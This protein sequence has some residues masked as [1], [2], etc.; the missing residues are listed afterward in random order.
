MDKSK[1]YPYIRTVCKKCRKLNEKPHTAE[2][3]RIQYKN[4]K[5]VH[6]AANKRWRT[7]NRQKMREHFHQKRLQRGLNGLSLERLAAFSKLVIGGAVTPK[8]LT[9]EQM[10]IVLYVRL[11]KLISE[12]II[13]NKLA[14]ELVCNFS[15][16]PFEALLESHRYSLR[17]QLC[18]FKK[19]EQQCQPM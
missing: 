14:Q 8:T 17:P 3:W 13:Q 6:I 7:K 4:N 19:G 9:V 2:Y 5:E 15:S 11:T 16:K 12:G 1:F 10:K 18:A